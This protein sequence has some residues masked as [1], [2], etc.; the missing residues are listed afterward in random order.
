MQSRVTKK[1]FEDA[2]DNPF[3]YVKEN[4][5]EEAPTISSF[6]ATCLEELPELAKQGVDEVAVRDVAGTIF[7]AGVDTTSAALKSFFLEAT[8]HPEMVLSAQKELDEVIGRDRLPEFS[9]MPD[10]PYISAIVKE[11]IRLTPPVPL[12]APHRAMED[13]IYEGQ[14]IPA[15][16]TIIDNV[17]AMLRDESVYPD[18]HTFNPERFLKDGQINPDVKDPDQMGAFGFGR[19]ACPGKYFALR[20][21]FLTISHTLATFD[22][23]KCLDE[24]G[25]PIIPKVEYPPAVFLHPGPF[26]SSIVPRS[27]QALSLIT[28]Q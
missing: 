15:G 14:F 22:I 18:P 8:L 6:V 24:D 9:D 7:L 27:A 2:I 17:W 4:L 10:L 26:P 20:V 23:S 12:G 11:V 3:K 13:D 5:Q 16:S 21:M 19:R 25:N 28:G 1:R